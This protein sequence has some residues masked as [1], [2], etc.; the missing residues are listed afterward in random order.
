M[1]GNNADSLDNASDAEEAFREVSIEEAARPEDTPKNFDGQNC[2]D[3][4][5]EIEIARIALNKFR[6]LVCQVRKEQRKK[7]FRT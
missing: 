2:I 1:H 3:C 4:F 6:C 7:F 5:E